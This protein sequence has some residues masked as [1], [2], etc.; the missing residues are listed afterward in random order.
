MGREERGGEREEGGGGKGVGR[1]RLYMSSF[2]EG[3]CRKRRGE[4]EGERKGE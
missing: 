4:S 1:G 3:N 2:C